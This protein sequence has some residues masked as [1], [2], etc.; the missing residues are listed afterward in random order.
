MAIIRQSRFHSKIMCD[1]T[2][3]LRTKTCLNTPDV[4][5][6]SSLFGVRNIRARAKDV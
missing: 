6:P 1:I 5:S 3:Q 2:F 4:F